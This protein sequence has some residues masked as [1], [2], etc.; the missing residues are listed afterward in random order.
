MSSNDTCNFNS[1]IIPEITAH[2]HTRE[3]SEINVKASKSLAI[4]TNA[5]IDTI[6]TETTFSTFTVYLK[7]M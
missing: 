4:K 5:S 1:L 6:T 7:N 2:T 3:D